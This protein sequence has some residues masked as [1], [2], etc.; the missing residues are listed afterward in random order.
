MHVVSYFNT[1]TRRC[2]NK[3]AL[4]KLEQ[5]I[6]AIP[7]YVEGQQE[8]LVLEQGL[9]HKLNGQPHLPA[10]CLASLGSRNCHLEIQDFPEPGLLQ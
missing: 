4:T 6:P 1:L 10:H 5:S 9:V 7:K 2:S 8:H 3:K